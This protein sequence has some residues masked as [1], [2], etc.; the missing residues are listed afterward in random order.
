MVEP[1]AAGY[2]DLLT[3]FGLGAFGLGATTAKVRSIIVLE[4]E[5]IS[6]SCGFGVP[7]FSFVGDREQLTAWSER[8]THEQIRAYQRGKNGVSI[9]GLRGLA[10]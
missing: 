1:G 8:K 9:D 4:V 7:L 10:R 2:D 5:R 6:D 3:A